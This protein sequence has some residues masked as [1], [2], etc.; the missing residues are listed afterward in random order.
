ME[1]PTTGAEREIRRLLAEYCHLCDEGEFVALAQ[2]FTSDGCFRYDVHTATGRDAIVRWFEANQPPERRGK[3]I[4]ANAVIDVD[5]GRAEVRSDYVFLTFVDGTLAP[6]LAGRYHDQLRR[7]GGR[8]LFERR[9]ARPLA[10][11]TVD[12]AGRAGPGS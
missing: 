2:R 12:R 8:W 3:H 5:G 1:A 9:E 6:A 7:V 4:T 10:A 11:P